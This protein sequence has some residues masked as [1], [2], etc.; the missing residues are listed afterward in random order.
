MRHVVGIAL[1]FAVLAATPALADPTI[2]HQAQAWLR[3]RKADGFTPTK[4]R[5]S[6]RKVRIE[7]RPPSCS[8]VSR[9]D[10]VRHRHAIVITTIY[11]TVRDSGPPYYV[12]PPCAPPHRFTRK[13]SLHGKLGRRAIRDGAFTPP[14]LRYRAPR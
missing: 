13:I 1:L 6:T 2:V 11:V 4:V 7:L 8:S 14:K 9:I 5:R 3:P 12:I 10:V